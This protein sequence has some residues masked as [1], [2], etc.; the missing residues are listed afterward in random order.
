MHHRRSERFGATKIQLWQKNKVSKLWKN[1]IL[2]TSSDLPGKTSWS[3]KMKKTYA[4]RWP[5]TPKDAF[6]RK[7]TAKKGST[8]FWN[9]MKPFFTNTGIITDSIALEEHG[10]LK[11][12]PKVTTKVF[13]NYY[14]S[15]VETTFGKRHYPNG[16]PD[17]KIN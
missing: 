12:D 5:N 15:V 3:I 4:I 6:F 11:N 7:V 13:D 10:V 16:N 17:L 14:I 1:L 2:K 9:G 8:S